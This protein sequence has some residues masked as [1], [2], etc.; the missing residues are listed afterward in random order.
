MRYESKND[1]LD[2]AL[3][4]AL[5]VDGK[6]DDALHRKVLYSWKEERAMKTGKYRVAAAAIAAIAGISVI[7]GG[8]YAAVT[9][10][11]MFTSFRFR[12]NSSQLSEEAEKL[13]DREPRIEVL[14]NEEGEAPLQYVNYTVD[15]VVCDDYTL[16]TRVT[17]TPKEPD[18]YTV[19][20][21]NIF[22]HDLKNPVSILK[23]PGETKG[24]IGEYATRGGKKI[25]SVDGGMGLLPGKVTG[26]S[27]ADWYE[28]GKD[29]ELYWYS[30]TQDTPGL[31]TYSEK[32]CIHE[33]EGIEDA[34]HTDGKDAS[35]VVT[36][37]AYVKVTVENES[38]VNIKKEYKTVQDTLD[39]GIK[40][41]KISAITTEIGTYLTIEH[42][43]QI[44]YD[45]PEDRGLI[46]AGIY[47]E[48]G[49]EIGVLEGGHG[50]ISNDK[51]VMKNNYG[52][53]DMSKVSIGFQ[54]MY[55][56]KHKV[57]DESVIGPYAI[58]EVK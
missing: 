38:H 12:S 7:S 14:D 51:A 30:C 15:E 1:K 46:V 32:L 5:H 20:G 6:P 26:G 29:G 27:T 9:N 24:T 36:G 28:Y 57:I 55:D 18:K 8:V 49:N 25:I 23:I 41:S 44:E 22:K 53:L 11:D 40:V 54:R 31:D 19:L 50:Y 34:M 17:I 3:K 16:Y 21:S 10:S 42:T 33:Y 13:V 48:D 47:D 35:Q 4:C 56:A 58:E 43:S 39:Y 45:G 52:P 2:R 37:S